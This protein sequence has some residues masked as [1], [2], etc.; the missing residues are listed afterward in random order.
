MHQGIKLLLVKKDQF[1]Q[2]GGNGKDCVEIWTVNGFGHSG[3]D[4]E[5]LVHDLTAGTV[6][7]AAGVV[8]YGYMT[9]VITDGY[10]A[11]K[12]SGL[13]VYDSGSHFVIVGIVW[14]GICKTRIK[15]FKGQLYG[16]THFIPP[17]ISKGLRVE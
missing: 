13:A 15:A 10:V 2:L 1:I 17:F 14:L 3:I 12:T 16:K 4:P 11:A 7:I 6:P 9:A 5:F 8:M